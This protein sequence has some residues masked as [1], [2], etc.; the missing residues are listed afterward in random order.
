MKVLLFLWLG[1]AAC[2]AVDAKKTP[3]A[4]D[5]SIFVWE[6]VPLFLIPDRTWIIG[7]T[8]DAKY[9]VKKQV[10]TNQMI[11][12]VAW[13]NLTNELTLLLLR[14]KGF[15]NKSYLIFDAGYERMHL[16]LNGCEL[17]LVSVHPRFERTRRYVWLQEGG[18]G[19]LL[20][21]GET[22]AQA[23]QE[24]SPQYQEFRKLWNEVEVIINKSKL[25]QRGKRWENPLDSTDP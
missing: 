10:L 8:G 16:K 17:E 14:S 21:P 18:E 2:W 13:T 4:P 3:S 19:R 25:Q 1:L 11:P 9:L 24:S 22:K 5:D 15:T 23:L 7:P 20:K 6:R 12:T